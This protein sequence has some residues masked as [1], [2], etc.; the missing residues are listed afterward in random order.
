MYSHGS[1]QDRIED[2]T[3]EYIVIILV[4]FFEK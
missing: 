2:K 3:A 4:V 1:Y